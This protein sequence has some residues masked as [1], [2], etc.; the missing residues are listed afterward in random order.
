MQVADGQDRILI[1]LGKCL[2]YNAESVMY[3]YVLLTGRIIWT[4]R[5]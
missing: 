4:L 3:V 5:I 2:L 1:A